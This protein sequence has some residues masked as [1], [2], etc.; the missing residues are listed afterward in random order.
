MTRPTTILGLLVRLASMRRRGV[1]VGG[2]ALLAVACSLG[3]CARAPEMAIV[4]FNIENFPRDERQIEGA[5]ATLRAL[6]V[7]VVAVQELI[8]P[9]RFEREAQARLGEEFEL[10][11]SPVGPVRRLGVLF[12]GDAYALS[13]ARAHDAT[14][15]RPNDRHVLEV[16]LAPHDGGRAL[17][18]LVVH[19]AAGGESEALRAEQLRLLL[20]IVRDAAASADELV[21]LGDFNSTGLPDR[22]RLAALARDTGL[23]WASEGLACTSYW[24]RLDGCVGSALD[25]VFVR[26]APRAIAARGP[27]EEF[28]CD[29]RD[30]CP[31]FHREVSDHCPITATLAP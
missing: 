20:P 3:R 1:V 15:L 16:R 10:V 2:V 23:T 4:T 7:P 6:D 14:R 29:R 5:F 9:A 11:V 31:A 28:G 17:R 8:D 30:Q 26:A 18:V 21:L 22:A 24:D 19:L 13:W 27:C 25:H 12:D